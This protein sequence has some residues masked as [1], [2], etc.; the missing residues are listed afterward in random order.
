MHLISSVPSMAYKAAIPPPAQRSGAKLE[1][2]IKQ[3]T[4]LKRNLSQQLMVIMNVMDCIFSIMDLPFKLN[5]LGIVED[6]KIPNDHHVIIGMIRGI[7]D[8]M[9]N[10]NPY[11]VFDLRNKITHLVCTTSSPREIIALKKLQS[12]L[13]LIFH[14]QQHLSSTL[15]IPP[16]E[17]TLVEKEK[18]KLAAIKQV[19]S[20]LSGKPDSSPKDIDSIRMDWTLY[21]IRYILAHPKQG[22]PSTRK[23]FPSLF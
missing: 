9:G 10:F 21:E 18:R 1:I 12:A 4:S 6:P 19:E 11:P 7:L 2:S 17:R 15:K 16:D 3:P 23:I 20:C 22:K 5:A 8:H 13:E 14:D